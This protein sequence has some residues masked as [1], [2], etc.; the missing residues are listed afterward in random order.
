MRRETLLRAARIVPPLLLLPALLVPSPASAEPPP[1][2]EIGIAGMLGIGDEGTY[3]SEFF[4]SED[5]RELDPTGG[6]GVHAL[7]E[8]LPYLDVGGR[9]AALWWQA[10]Q[11]VE[12]PPCSPLR[13]PPAPPAHDRRQCRS[14]RRWRADRPR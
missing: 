9:V 4:D 10:V 5:D 8:V 7:Y 13:F 6:F 1:K 11:A 14:W 3:T 12:P 2:V